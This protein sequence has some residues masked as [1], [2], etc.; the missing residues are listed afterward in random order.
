[1]T[2]EDLK[3]IAQQFIRAS[4]QFQKTKYGA[5]KVRISRKNTGSC[6]RRGH[7]LPAEIESRFHRNRL[8]LLAKRH[9]LEVDKNGASPMELLRNHVFG[10][11]ES[12]LSR[13][14]LEASLLESAYPSGSDSHEDVLLNTARRY[15]IDPDKVE[16]SWP[17][18]SKLNKK[19]GDEI[20]V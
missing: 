19:E 12:G 14:L 20:R 5:V 18:S 6:S 1:L 13:F 7:G 3:E 8:P 17:R 10:Y 11:D 4:S 16:K 2:Y 15:R 9:K